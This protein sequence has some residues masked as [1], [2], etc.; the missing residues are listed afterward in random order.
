[1]HRGDLD[2]GQRRDPA[3]L[4]EARGVARRQDS[5]GGERHV[6][7]AWSPQCNVVLFASAGA[8]AM[9][10]PWPWVTSSR[11][12]L[13][14]LSRFLYCAGVS[15]FLI[16]HGSV[17]NYFSAGVVILNADWPSQRTSTFPDCA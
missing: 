10:S 12:T 6:Q 14:R 1:M 4:G 2:A 11:S 9:W 13:P 15:G 8:S 16:S 3:A 17:T 7:V 5:K